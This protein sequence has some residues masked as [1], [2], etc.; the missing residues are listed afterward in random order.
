MLCDTLVSFL[1]PAPVRSNLI[2]C[3]LKTCGVCGVV[4]MRTICCEMSAETELASEPQVS[5]RTEQTGQSRAGPGIAGAG[6]GNYQCGA[7]PAQYQYNNTTQV[8]LTR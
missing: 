3:V 4:R 1:A 6:V 5:H 8:A 7:T 2:K